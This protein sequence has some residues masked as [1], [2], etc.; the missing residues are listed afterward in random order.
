MRTKPLKQSEQSELIE[1]T[2]HLLQQ[3]IE[4]SN[5]TKLSVDVTDEVGTTYKIEVKQLEPN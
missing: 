1:M 3:I 4:N 2:L 5:E